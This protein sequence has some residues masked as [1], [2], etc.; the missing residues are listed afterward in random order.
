MRSKKPLVVILG[1]FMGLGLVACGGG[2]S[3]SSSATTG[4][5]PTTSTAAPTTAGTEPTTTETAP[6]ATDYSQPEHW[7]S[8]PTSADKPVDVFY[9]YPTEYVKPAAGG[10]VVC[11]SDDPGMMKGAKAAFSRQATAFETVGNIY[12]PYYRQ[13]DAA[14]RAAMPQAEQDQVVAGAPTE[15]GLAAFEYYIAHYNAGRPF[16]LA[17]HSLGSN[18]LANL[19]A[20]Y[21]KEHPDVYKRMIAAYVIGYSIS[22]SYLTQNPH[23]KF[24]EG[25]D[26]T[27]VIISYNTEAPEVVGT[28]PVIPARWP[29]H[30]PDHVGQDREARHGGPE[31]GVHHAE[32]RWERGDERSRTHRAREE[33]GRCADQHGRGKC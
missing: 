14:S 12:A 28:N 15:D 25:P 3:S 4:S 19:L 27:G 10:P 29:G 18:V 23:L 24:A 22:P 13:A 20:D 17:G 2:G 26:D 5:A 11:T 30:Q 7:L 32:R 33:P 6:Q 8:L 21:M 9:L 1:L 16:I 31:P